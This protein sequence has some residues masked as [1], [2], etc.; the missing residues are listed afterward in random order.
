MT[1]SATA[2]KK[3]KP[4]NAWMAWNYDNPWEMTTRRLKR[5]CIAS[6]RECLINPDTD[7]KAFTIRKVV[8]MPCK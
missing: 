7:I 4:V 2:R 6:V 1:T 3:L 5:D 8:V